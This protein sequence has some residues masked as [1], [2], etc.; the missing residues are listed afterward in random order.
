MHSDCFYYQTIVTIMMDASMQM[1][2]NYNRF[3]KLLLDF[4]LIL[5]MR[6]LNSGR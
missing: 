2:V 3:L 5:E 6:K 1:S 4:L